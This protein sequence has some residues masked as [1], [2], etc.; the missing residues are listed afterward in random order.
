MTISFGCCRTLGTLVL[1]LLLLAGCGDDPPAVQ[2]A[3]EGDLSV[4]LD[5]LLDLCV[6]GPAGNPLAR[7]APGAVLLVDTP[8]GRYLKAKGV[9]DL[10]SGR[11]LRADDRLQ[12]GSNT[13]MFTGVLLL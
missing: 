6:Q 8:E 13:K 10:G 11:P 12:I 2:P 9:A 1:G 3:L 7:P 5:Q 4:Q